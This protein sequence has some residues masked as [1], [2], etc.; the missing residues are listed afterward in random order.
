MYSIFATKKGIYV[1]KHIKIVMPVK[2]KYFP[3]KTKNLSLNYIE[4]MTWGQIGI[5]HHTYV[6]NPTRTVISILY[7]Y[8]LCL[9][10]M[11]VLWILFKIIGWIFC[12]DFFLKVLIF[13]KH[14]LYN[15]LGLSFW[16]IY[17]WYKSNKS[18]KEE[19]QLCNVSSFKNVQYMQS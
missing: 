12:V 8:F 7:F 2:L 17:I 19:L 10:V 9:W 1:H 15:F 13:I 6:D 5:Q 14:L 3:L 11:W 18:L 4:I 16:I